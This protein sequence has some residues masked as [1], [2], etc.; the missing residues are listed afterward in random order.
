M[1]LSFRYRIKSLPNCCNWSRWCK[2]GKNKNGELVT[3]IYEK[4]FDFETEDEISKAML[5]IEIMPDF[6]K[7]QFR[8]E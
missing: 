5:D 3:S 4:G 8:T 1:K 7:L 6:P 2:V